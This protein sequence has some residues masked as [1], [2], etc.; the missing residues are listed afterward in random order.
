MRIIVV[1]AGRIGYNLCKSLAEE[2]HEIYLI[3]RNEILVEK[4]DEKLDVKVVCGS[5]TDPETLKK[6]NISEADLMIAVTRSDEINL[7]VCSLASFFGCR[8]QI[9]RVRNIS[10]SKEIAVSGYSHFNL[11]AIINPEHLASQAIEK[12]IAAPGAREVGD[13][14]NGRILLRAFDIPENSPLCG[15]KIQNLREEDFPWPFL[16]IAISRK[17]EVIIPSGETSI[18]AADRIYVLLPFESLGEFLSFVDPEIKRPS[19][20]II[21]GATDTGE[22]L[23]NA[24]S[25]HIKDIILLE[26][27]PIKAEA[28]AERLE[29]VR[30]LNGSASELD[31]LAESGIEATDIFVAASDDDDTNLISAVLAKKM[32]AKTTIIITQ[33][34][35]YTSMIDAL[36]IDVAIN[37]Q[38]LAVEQ[39]LSF[40]RGESISAVTKLMEGNAEALE[41]IAEKGSIVTKAPIKNIK[42]PENS[43]VGAVCRDDE[44]VL[45]NGDTQIK[46]NEKVIVFCQHTAVKKLQTLFTRKQSILPELFNK[47]TE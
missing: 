4:T 9:A 44:V 34:T 11:D 13:F 19:K 8:R 41:L 47:K 7:V 29:S 12:T 37:P 17:G 35:D 18:E 28:V 39:I 1:G 2:N 42:F 40:V 30:V 25:T 16:I 20:V 5:G 14:A 15:I 3:E 38:M 45:A 10:L 21:Y 26:E 23:A 33:H 36:G 6:V 32:G 27:S 43:I 46:E 31:I 24:L 22:Q